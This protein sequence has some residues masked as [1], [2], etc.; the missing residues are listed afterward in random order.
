M[1]LR[2]LGAVY[3]VALFAATGVVA[4]SGDGKTYMYSKGVRIGYI[5]LNSTNY[6]GVECGGY[7]GAHVEALRRRLTVS[8][9]LDDASLWRICRTYIEAARGKPCLARTDINSLHVY[10][11]GLTVKVNDD[12]FPQHANIVGWDAARARQQQLNLASKA[13]RVVKA[14]R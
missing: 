8:T 12:P 9:A 3:L 1:I 2:L 5:S 4:A 10:A 14:P 11:E 13:E 7:E 6:W